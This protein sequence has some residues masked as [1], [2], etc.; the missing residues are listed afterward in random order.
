VTG[1]LDVD[2]VLDHRDEV[3]HDLDDSVQLPWDELAHDVCGRDACGG[4]SISIAF[5]CIVM[6]VRPP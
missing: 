2:A 5:S 1:A 4:S 6:A 3:I